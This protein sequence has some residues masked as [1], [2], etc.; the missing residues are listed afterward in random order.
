MH[1]PVTTTHSQGKSLALFCTVVDNYGDIGICWR[2]ARQLAHEH[3]ILVTL[4]V[5]DLRSFKRICPEVD[6]A[7]EQQHIQGIA[8]RFWRDQNGTFAT[9]DIAD[10]VIEFFG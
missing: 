8:V 2:L 5:D 10:I 1:F 7:A 6:A 4:W 3:G 9:D